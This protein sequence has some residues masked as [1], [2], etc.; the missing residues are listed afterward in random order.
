MKNVYVQKSEKDFLATLLLCFLFGGFGAH[1]FYTEKTA[2]AFLMLFTLGGL[3]LWT[4]IDIIF[5]A[6]GSFKDHKGLLI[7]N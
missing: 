1:R 2:S 4:F 5:I 7:K 6:T 3:G